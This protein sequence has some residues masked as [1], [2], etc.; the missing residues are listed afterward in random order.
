VTDMS[1]VFF[2]AEAFNQ[3]LNWDTS[4]VTRMMYMFYA[5]I[6]F[7]QPIDDWDTS[8]VTTMRNMFDGATS[9][10]QPLFDITS[11]IN[12]V[13]MFRGATSFIAALACANLDPTRGGGCDTDCQDATAWINAG[14][15]GTC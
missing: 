4:K 8:S 14:C 12:T 3:P 6:A 11:D 10:N 13:N 5:A 9:F 7:N 2:R 15:C 1:G